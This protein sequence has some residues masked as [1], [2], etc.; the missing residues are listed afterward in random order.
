MCIEVAPFFSVSSV[1]V[2]PKRNNK[3]NILDSNCGAN[4][5]MKT[6]SGS[7]QLGGSKFETVS[8]TKL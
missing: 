8:G 4:S 1:L 7:K 5:L 2:S 3:K 6:K